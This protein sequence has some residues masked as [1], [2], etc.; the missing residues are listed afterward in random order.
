MRPVLH[1]A[2]A[3]ASNAVAERQRRRCD[4]DVFIGKLRTLWK[5]ACRLAF[6]V[7]S[8]VIHSVSKVGCII[9]ETKDRSI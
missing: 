1:A 4:P 9:G 8:L 7:C 2:R 5:L 3:I 6:I